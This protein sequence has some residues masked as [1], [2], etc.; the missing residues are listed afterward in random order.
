MGKEDRRDRRAGGPTADGCVDPSDRRRGAGDPGC[1]GGAIRLAMDGRSTPGVLL[2]IGS[3][4]VGALAGLLTPS[5]A[6]GQHEA[7]A[8]D[9][10]RV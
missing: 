4:A 3:G 7:A 9:A 5:P 10:R 6:G 2:A 8:W 1:S